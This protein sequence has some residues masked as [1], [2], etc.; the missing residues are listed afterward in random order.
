MIMFGGA[1]RGGGSRLTPPKVMRRPNRSKNFS[2][3]AYAF[4]FKGV[5]S[6]RNSVTSLDARPAAW[7]MDRLGSFSR[8][9]STADTRPVVTRPSVSVV[10]TEYR[11]AD[12]GYGRG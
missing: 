4:V 12:A 11:S 9:S 6:L 2:V 10:R 1:L 5:P 8:S 3:T 7:R